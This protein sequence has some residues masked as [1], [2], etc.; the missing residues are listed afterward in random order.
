LLIKASHPTS[1]RVLP[2]FAKQRGV[3]FF[4]QVQPSS[5]CTIAAV[6]VHAY[7]TRERGRSYQKVIQAWT[8]ERASFFLRKFAGW[9]QADL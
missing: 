1:L 3:Y 6:S 2:L 5:A 7:Y 4:V 8:L 9:R